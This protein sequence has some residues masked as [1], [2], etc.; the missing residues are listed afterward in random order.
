MQADEES[1]GSEDEYMV[2]SQQL[3][4]YLMKFVTPFLFIQKVSLSKITVTAFFF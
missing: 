4:L 1:W 2:V 3:E